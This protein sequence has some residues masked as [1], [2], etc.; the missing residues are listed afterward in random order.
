VAILQVGRGFLQ[1]GGGLLQV[2]E[3]PLQVGGKVVQVGGE[4]KWGGNLQNGVG[5]SYLCTVERKKAGETPR[6]TGPSRRTDH[7][8]AR[9]KKVL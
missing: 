2:G 3:S 1:V 9:Q 4:K 5:M 8:P 7:R 6:S